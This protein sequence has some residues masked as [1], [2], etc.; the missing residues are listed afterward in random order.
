MRCSPGNNAKSA[1]PSAMSFPSICVVAIVSPLPMRH[2]L[3]RMPICSLGSG[4]PSYIFCGLGLRAQPMATSPVSMRNIWRDRRDDVPNTPETGRAIIHSPGAHRLPRLVHQQQ[5]SHDYCFCR[6]TRSPR[7]HTA[8][9]EGTS[10][11]WNHLS[12]GYTDQSKKCRGTLWANRRGTQD[13]GLGR[14]KAWPTV[15]K[16]EAWQRSGDGLISQLPRA[17]GLGS[18]SCT[19][20]RFLRSQFSGA[21]WTT[22]LA[23]CSV[24]NTTA[25]SKDS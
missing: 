1:Q 15:R 7:E 2:P 13:R 6:I 9:L 21:G 8:T 16:R 12:K 4:G 23:P 22:L 25:G 18:L 17:I 24:Q 11:K 5:L 3:C 14:A 20:S 10:P 19:R